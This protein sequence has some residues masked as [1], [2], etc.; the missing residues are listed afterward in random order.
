LTIAV[1][2]TFISK[3]WSALPS[4]GVDFPPPLGP[5]S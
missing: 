4:P 3:Q 1:F 2:N 5:I